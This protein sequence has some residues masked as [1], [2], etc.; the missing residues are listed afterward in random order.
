MCQQR[1]GEEVITTAGIGWN[2]PE[3]G[4][5]KMGGGMHTLL[6]KGTPK[7]HAID[8]DA[9]ILSRS[10]WQLDLTEQVVHVVMDDLLVSTTQKLQLV[11]GARAYRWL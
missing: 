6:S 8:G 9:E 5:R 1:V 3:L 11:V 4:V 7:S 10:K 2:S